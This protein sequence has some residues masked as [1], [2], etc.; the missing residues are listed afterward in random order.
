MMP[1]IARNA[2]AQDPALQRL[3]D[4]RRDP[5]GYLR[6][7][8]YPGPRP[9][10]VFN[11]ANFAFFGIYDYAMLTSDPTAIRLVRGHLTTMRRY[12][13]A[14]RVP[15]GI[16]L[17]DLTHR[18]R[19]AHYHAV[20]TWQLGMLGRMGGGRWFTRLGRAFHADYP[21]AIYP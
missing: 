14:Y 21:W 7:E 19:I 11:G 18:S 2:H 20:D 3:A 1:T 12:A 9:S 10:H 4:E 8:E 16:S 17:Y 6:L 5:N 15:G 13:I